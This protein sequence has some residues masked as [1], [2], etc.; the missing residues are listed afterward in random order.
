MIPTASLRAGSVKAA[1]PDLRQVEQKLIISRD[2][3]PPLYSG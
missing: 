2:P 3:N 1:W